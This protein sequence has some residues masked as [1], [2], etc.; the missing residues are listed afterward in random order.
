M[1]CNEEMRSRVLKKGRAKQSEGGMQK[2]R[3]ILVC[4]SQR[5]SHTLEEHVDL[6]HSQ[7]RNN[8]Q[9]VNKGRYKSR[10]TTSSIKG[11]FLWHWFNECNPL[12]CDKGAH[13][14]SW[15]GKH[16]QT[17]VLSHIALSKC[18]A[19]L[20]HHSPVSCSTHGH[21]LVCPLINLHTSSAHGCS[22][23]IYLWLSMVVPLLC[24]GSFLI[25]CVSLDN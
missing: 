16:N 6:A 22:D 19:A 17:T 14:V 5:G 24:V 4:M 13:N 25:I 12:V 23:I 11:T 1:G 21:L 8:N 2:L 18:K 9:Q 15:R 10:R 20:M 7:M 3:R